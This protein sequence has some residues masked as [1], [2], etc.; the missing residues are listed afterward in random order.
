MPRIDPDDVF[1]DSRMSFGEHIEELR[2]HL[3]RAIVG[4]IAAVAVC[5]AADGVGNALGNKDIGV[6]R[7]MLAVII[8][9]VQSMSKSF[10]EQR[11]RKSRNDLA[12]ARLATPPTAE[13]T[14]QLKERYRTNGDSTDGFTAEEKRQFLLIPLPV[15]ATLPLAALKTALD[16]PPPRDPGGV[17][18]FEV[19]VIPAELNVAATQGELLLGNKNYIST[20]SAQE[21]MVTYF[22]VLLLCSAVLASPWILYQLW[23]FVAAGLYPSERAVVYRMFWPSVSLFVAGVLLCQFLVLPGA[24]KALIG[25]NEWLDLEPDIRLNEWLG[26]ALTL[27]LVFGVSFQTPLVMVLLNRLGTFSWQD[28]WARWRGAALVLAVFSAIITPTPDAITMMYLFVPMYGLY[29]LGIGVCRYFPPPHEALAV[30]D[31]LA[32]VAV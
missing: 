16:L 4:L 32:Q 25:F 2:T 15:K 24:V 29:M 18:E 22:K 6:G 31:T 28:Y 20:L 7:P 30:D 17:F 12:D 3:L 10:Y 26:L 5:G 23:A 21:A 11:N 8:A 14:A 19:Q 1:A 13:E 9:P 27:P